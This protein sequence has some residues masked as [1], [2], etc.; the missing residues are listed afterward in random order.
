MGMS[1]TA[2]V[3]T[4]AGALV[5]VWDAQQGAELGAFLADAAHPHAARLPTFRVGE[6]VRLAFVFGLGHVATLPLPSL[7]KDRAKQ[8]GVSM[9]G[10]MGGVSAW[11]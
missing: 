7:A 8:R 10:A 11:G 6:S 5:Q 2:M 1:D 9:F 4:A 3:V